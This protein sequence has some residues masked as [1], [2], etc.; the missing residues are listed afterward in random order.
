MLNSGLMPTA[1]GWSKYGDPGDKALVTK[2]AKAEAEIA[3]LLAKGA[4][5]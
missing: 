5:A 1:D 3:H 2:I 4:K